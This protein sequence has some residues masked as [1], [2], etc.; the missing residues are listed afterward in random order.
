MTSF[1]FEPRSGARELD[2]ALD[3]ALDAALEPAT[4]PGWYES[5]WD[6]SRGLQV[7]EDPDEPLA[8]PDESGR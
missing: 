6:L 3:P 4:G 2:A 8:A 7:V 1:N 5:S